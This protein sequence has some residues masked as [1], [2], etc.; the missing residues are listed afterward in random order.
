MGPGRPIAVLNPLAKQPVGDLDLRQ[1]DHLLTLETLQILGLQLAQ[2]LGARGKCHGIGPRVEIA[3]QII[4]DRTA[5]VR[6]LQ[7]PI[8]GLDDHGS[9][10]CDILGQG[11]YPRLAPFDCL[12][13]LQPE[14][15]KGGRTQRFTGRQLWQPL[16]HPARHLVSRLFAKGQQQYLRRRR[17]LSLQQIGRPPHQDAGLATAST[18]QYQ[19]GRLIDH[20][21]LPLAR[22]QRMTLE[23][24][25][26]FRMTTQHPTAVTLLQTQQGRRLL[27][28]P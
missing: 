18:G 8:E 25:K 19:I 2:I 15:M 1:T 7:R 9:A 11:R 20:T 12:D 21:G 26:Q 23:C 22:R 27:K 5:V 14:S 4:E 16:C 6:I 13:D 10:L 3:A 28:L 24:V 17:Q